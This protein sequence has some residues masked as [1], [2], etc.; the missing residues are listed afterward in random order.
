M[1]SSIINLGIPNVIGTSS[2][3]GTRP[4][5]GPSCL[6]YISLII[7]ICDG[8]ASL[9]VWN[10]FIKVGMVNNFIWE[11]PRQKMRKGQLNNL[12]PPLHKRRSRANKPQMFNQKF[13]HRE[14][15]KD[16]NMTILK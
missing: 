7:I 14:L 11:G 16:L 13:G 5:N 12:M 8:V 6:F 15:V 4:L 9:H 2:Q 3:N 1:I 10:L